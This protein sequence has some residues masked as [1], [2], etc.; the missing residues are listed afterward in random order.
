MQD[1]LAPRTCQRSTRSLIQAKTRAALGQAAAGDGARRRV[2]GWFLGNDENRFRSERV[3]GSESDREIGRG[4][5][6]V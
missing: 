3:R 4:G 2:A 1:T 5:S 6:L